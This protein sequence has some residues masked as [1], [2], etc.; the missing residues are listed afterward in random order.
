MKKIF[1]AVVFLLCCT[2]LCASPC[3]EELETLTLSVVAA[4]A[5]KPE[6]SLPG[7][8]KKGSG[9]IPESV[10]FSSSDVSLYYEA[11]TTRPSGLGLVD[12]ALFA[13]TQRTRIMKQIQEMLLSAGYEEGDLI[14]D[15]TI[16]IK[17]HKDV[18]EMK[19]A[20]S[21]DLSSISLSVT[22]DLILAERGKVW[23]AK[24]TL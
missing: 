13:T 1:A 17:S 16:K 10:K 8:V 6:L 2:V 23:K 15:G 19:I 7:V 5:S 3:F 18:D 24:G 22:V 9:I 12:S 11:L 4:T 21:S 14:V 20:L